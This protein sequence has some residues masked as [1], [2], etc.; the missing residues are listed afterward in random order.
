M[1]IKYPK[2][3]FEGMLAKPQKA[4]QLPKGAISDV[5][6]RGII[7]VFVKVSQSKIDH[8]IAVRQVAEKMRD[9][10]EHFEKAIILTGNWDILLRTHIFNTKEIQGVLDKLSLIGEC[11]QITTS[12]ILDEVKPLKK[13]ST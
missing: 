10:V 4:M 7:L 5:D 12:I 9:T 3:N 11:S 1:I 8:S 13:P 6:R 2:V